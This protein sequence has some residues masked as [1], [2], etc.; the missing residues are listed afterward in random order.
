MDILYDPTYCSFIINSRGIFKKENI[1]D[2]YLAH[3]LQIINKLPTSDNY[4]C[5]I[6][7]T[8]NDSFK[9]IFYGSDNF[10]INFNDDHIRLFLKKWNNNINNIIDTKNIDTKNID[11]EFQST[12]SENFWKEIE[13][14]VVDPNVETSD[15]MFP[16]IKFVKKQKP[17]TIAFSHESF[18]IDETVFEEIF[19]DYPDKKY[20]CIFHNRGKCKNLDPKDCKGLHSKLLYIITYDT[21]TNIYKIIPTK[22]L[23]QNV[24]QEFEDGIKNES[25]N[26]KP[27]ICHYDN[28]CIRAL[29]TCKTIGGQMKLHF[30]DVHQCIDST[31][32]LK[33]I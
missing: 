25:N 27:N 18:Y 6:C 14:I 23:R 1:P 22:Y 3:W 10:V 5:K 8:G 33:L 24:R 16:S 26:W 32:E 4:K 11:K 17:R 21:L 9:I 12:D 29:N 20:P 2:P 28:N 31:Y 30:K 19:Y 13:Q 7:P 15:T